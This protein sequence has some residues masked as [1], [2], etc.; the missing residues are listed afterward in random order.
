MH[1][2]MADKSSQ[3]ELT[4]QLID[5]LR[6]FGKTKSITVLFCQILSNVAKHC[7][8]LD[9]TAQLIDTLHIFLQN[10]RFFRIWETFF[11]VLKTN[12]KVMFC[13]ILPNIEQWE[14]TT[15]LID[16]LRIFVKTSIAEHSSVSELD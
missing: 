1:C 7:Q 6:S 13:Q 5:T 12:L 4:T 8:T 11:V 15:Q 14:L 3:K 16:T 10:I 2:E 9:L